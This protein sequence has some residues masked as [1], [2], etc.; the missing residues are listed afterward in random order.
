MK[1]ILL[2]VLM[3]TSFGCAKADWTT[4]PDNGKDGAKGSDCVATQ[5]EGGAM[6]KCGTDVPVFIANGTNGAQGPKGDKG[7]TGPAGLNGTNG[8]N[9]AQGP[10]GDKGDR[11]EKGDKGT[12]GT[13]G[14]HGSKGDRG[15]DGRNGNDGRNGDNGR[16]GNKGDK[17]D[18]T[19]TV[20]D[21][22]TE[23]QCPTRGFVYTTFLDLNNNGRIDEGETIVSA[24]VV[25]DGNDGRNGDK[26]EQGNNGNDGRNGDNG[27]DG[28]NGSQGSKGDRGDRGDNGRDGLAGNNGSNGSR[29]DKGD[30]GDRGNDGVNGSKGDKGDSDSTQLLKPCNGK[31]AR[32]TRLSNGTLMSHTND[33]GMTDLDWATAGSNAPSYSIGGCNSCTVYV[34]Y[35][36]KVCTVNPLKGLCVNPL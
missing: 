9:G 27:R 7:D 23:A 12:N 25:C 26:G 34:D 3:A 13:N 33:D 2:I 4:K 5:V 32:I 28:S 1:K 30:K 36:G 15:D 16:D 31:K 8:T 18:R 10:K 24:S 17:G 29:G 11:G 14:E 6:V 19:Y 22:A 21:P 20:T 35:A